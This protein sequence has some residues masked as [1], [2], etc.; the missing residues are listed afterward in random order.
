M[1][2]RGFDYCDSTISDSGRSLSTA[3]MLWNE[4]AR[5][6]ERDFEK[7]NVST[8]WKAAKVQRAIDKW[9]AEYA[10][11]SIFKRVWLSITGNLTPRPVM[12]T[13]LAHVPV[14]IKEREYYNTIDPVKKD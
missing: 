9:D 13:D 5:F 11:L 8:Y 12:P 14:F 3:I 2:W 10:K 4:A 7:A 1:E 6:I